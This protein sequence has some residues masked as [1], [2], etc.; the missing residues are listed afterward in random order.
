MSYDLTDEQRAGLEAEL[1]GRRTYASNNGK[2]PDAVV[3][4]RASSVE[5][6]AVEWL[7]PERVPL[8]GSDVACGQPRPR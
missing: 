2:H 7:V 6:E 1:A 8:G 3:A 4:I 5:P